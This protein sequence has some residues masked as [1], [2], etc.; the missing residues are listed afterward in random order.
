[1]MRAVARFALFVLLAACSETAP[2]EFVELVEASRG[3]SATEECT[4]A[5]GGECT[6]ATPVNVGAVEEIDEAAGEVECEGATI[7]CADNANVRCEAGRCIS[8]GSP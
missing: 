6:C 3:C 5:G 7:S 2:S 4:V 1:M 8:D